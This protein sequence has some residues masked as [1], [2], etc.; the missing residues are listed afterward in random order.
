MAVSKE[1]AFFVMGRLALLCLLAAA[2][3]ATP[4][5]TYV[6]EF[7]RRILSRADQ[8]VLG[9]VLQVNPPFRGISSARLAVKEHL[10]GYDRGPDLML[11]YTEDFVAPEALGGSYVRTSAAAKPDLGR[12]AGGG[13]MKPGP[14]ETQASGGR[15][16]AALGV[17]LAEG[18]EGLFFLEKGS[19]AYGV[20][21]VLARTDPLFE[22]KEA[23]LRAVLAIEEEA[24]LDVKV[25]RARDYHLAGLAE[26]E[27][28]MRGNSARELLGL[29]DRHAETF[30][31]QECGRIAAALAEEAEPV[32]RD[33]LERT[34]RKLDPRAAAEWI[35][36]A[37]GRDATRFKERVDEERKRLQATRSDEI[38]AA[39][40][41]RVGRSYRRAASA[42]LCELLADPAAAVRARAAEALGDY[43]GPSA[44]EPLRTALRRERDTDAARAM[45]EACGSL[46]DPDAVEVLA[47]RI[48]DR[49]LERPAL[50]ALARIGTPEARALLEEREK[51]ADAETTAFIE[52]LLRREEGS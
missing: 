20:L 26:K 19:Q 45:I 10:A 51:S 38:R 13:G 6:T 39:E 3:S 42:L 12:E 37:E 43:A 18:D 7:G 29:A 14:K 24:A 40:V 33:L 34:L 44:R 50:T 15:E 46:A 23:R 1:T 2:V 22:V 17:R 49:T 9:R 21:A 48:P 30:S 8:I 47:R 36:E 31:A 27:P 52:G 11:L 25:R 4:G 28:W 41:V 5:R 16:R 35:A 32:V